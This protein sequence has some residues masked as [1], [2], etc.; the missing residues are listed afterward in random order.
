MVRPNRHR[1]VKTLLFVF[2]CIASQCKT[3][4]LLGLSGSLRAPGLESRY[5]G[6]LEVE[7]C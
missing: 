6:L 3:Y 5:S 7:F 2:V 4:Y 1:F